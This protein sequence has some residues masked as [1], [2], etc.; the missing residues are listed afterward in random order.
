MA[1]LLESVG[2]CFTKFREFLV[3][4]SSSTLFT[5][6]SFLST[7]RTPMI[8]MLDLLLVLVNSFGLLFPSVYSLCSDCVNTIYL[9]SI[10]LILSS[11]IFTLLNDFHFHIDPIQWGFVPNVVFLSFIISVCLKRIWNWLL[12]HF[13]VWCLK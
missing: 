5:H 4:I 1:K 2:F 12:K 3:I 7:L 13:Y 9:F 8:Q 6:A 10:S 11:V